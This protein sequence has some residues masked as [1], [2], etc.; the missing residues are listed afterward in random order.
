MFLFILKCNRGRFGTKKKWN[1]QNRTRSKQRGLWEIVENLKAEVVNYKTLP[2]LSL[3]SAISFCAVFLSHRLP[4]KSCLLC[5]NQRGCQPQ[6]I[7]MHLRSQ[8]NTH[9]THSHAAIHKKHT[10]TTLIGAYKG[11]RMR[12]HFTW[13]LLYNYQGSLLMWNLCCSH[14]EPIYCCKPS[15]TCHTHT[16]RGWW[17]TYTSTHTHTQRARETYIYTHTHK[18]FQTNAGK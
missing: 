3:W 6:H 11:E 2:A 4:G 18:P 16:H 17:F 10:T 1:R 9:I 7:Q 8:T 15:N 5:N 13:L 14:N 12:V